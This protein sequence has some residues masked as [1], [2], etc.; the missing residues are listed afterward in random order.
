MRIGILGAGS[1]G[2]LFASY[3]GKQFDVTLF[4]RRHEQMDLINEKGVTIE[5]LDST[6]T[7][8]VRA[9]LDKNEFN[10]QE[11][12]IIAV[13][14]YHLENI[15]A[16]I[17]NIHNEIPLLF[18]QNGKSHLKL[19]NHLEHESI[20]VG[21]IEHGALKINETTVVHNGIGLTKLAPYRGEINRISPLL[22][23]HSEYF[24]FKIYLDYKEILL[25]KLLV[26]AIINPLTAILKVKNGELIKNTFF[27]R[28]FH[29]LYNE[30]IPL[31]PE[32]DSK[33]VLNEIIRI[34]RNTENNESSMLKDITLQRKTEIDAIVGYILELAKEKNVQLPLTNMVYG[35]IKGMEKSGIE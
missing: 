23:W 4:P 29:D 28:I 34:C 18:L 20:I 16:D 27:M 10:K 13:K 32:L 35:M 17:T 30:I 9:T 31:F 11:L 1:I 21:S 15:Q 6:F 14:Q 22:N 8:R 5:T 7:T 19:I 33:M 25:K 26:N 2:L 12:I 3:L 24:Q